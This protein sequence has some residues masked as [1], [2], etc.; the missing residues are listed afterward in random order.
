MCGCGLLDQNPVALWPTG[1]HFGFYWSPNTEPLPHASAVHITPLKSLSVRALGELWEL[2][3]PQLQALLCQPFFWATGSVRTWWWRSPVHWSCPGVPDRQGGSTGPQ[4]LVS[5]SLICHTNF[6]ACWG[7]WA[8]LL[9]FPPPPGAWRTR[10]SLTLHPL[11]S[12]GLASAADQV[13]G[14]AALP[15]V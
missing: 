3:T 14:T 10:L 11:P 1:P 15:F 12:M 13:N 6:S 9:P 2:T 4:P 7:A 8:A 5:P